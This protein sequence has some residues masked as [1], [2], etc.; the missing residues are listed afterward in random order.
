MYRKLLVLEMAARSWRICTQSHRWQKQ[1]ITGF[2]CLI[3]ICRDRNCTDCDRLWRYE[4]H[5]L[6]DRDREI[7]QYFQGTHITCWDILCNKW[8]FVKE[9][10]TRWTRASRGIPC[11]STSSGEFLLNSLHEVP[12]NSFIRSSKEEWWLVNCRD[13]KLPMKTYMLL[14]CGQVVFLLGSVNCEHKATRECFTW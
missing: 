14:Q 13:V 2:G 10:Q 6:I 11:K 7:L 12:G 9:P 4:W 8:W 3:A 5:G 1:K